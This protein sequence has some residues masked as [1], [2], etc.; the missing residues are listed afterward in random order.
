VIVG[1]GVAGMEAALVLRARDAEAG[2]TILS[3][4]HDHFF[5][6]PALMYVFAAQMS[7]QDTEPYDRGLYE[8]MRFERVR[9]RASGLDAPGHA[10]QL[11]DGSRLAYDRLLL[12]VG[13]RGRAAPWPGAAG[14]GLHHFVTLGDLAGLDRDARPGRR[15]VVV[16][17]GLIGVEVAEVLHDRGLH[18]T[19]VIRERW[20]F[21]A[22]LE[23]R[24]AALV[25][26]HLRG[27]G[28]DVRLEAVVDEVVRETGGRLR[29]VKLAPA[30]G[31]AGVEAAL[32]AD[33]VPADLVACAI[34]VVPRTGFLAGSAVA[35]AANG[36]IETDDALRTTA[37]DV[38]AAGDCAN[39]TTADGRRR[40]EQLW[41]TAREQGRAAGR[42]LLG[43]AVV[44]R[45]SASFNSAKFFDLEWTT[46]GEV[47][48]EASPEGERV[49]LPEGVS[50]WFQRV[51]GRLASQRVVVREGRVIGF[52]MLGSRW[53]HEPL[54]EWIAERRPLE[55]VLAHLGEAR[56]DEEFE[57]R[58]RVQAKANTTG[59][60]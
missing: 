33:L 18:V 45:R 29:A 48:S 2:I 39:V 57:P 56:F 32:P 55:W 17:G 7:L 35:L 59:A 20:P 24:E 5:S 15:A 38:W 3:D 46:A 21:P 27:C 25:A 8:R 43:D 37:P 51:P 60:A 50:S 4:E 10:L 26:E 49:P 52:N 58:F 22:A 31:G 13:S 1:N 9:G 11:E 41:Y 28:I 23:P 42:S 44:Y 12:A 30:P 16:G 47:P 36:G 40:V 54:L 6:R 53:D 19:F 14:P 34:G